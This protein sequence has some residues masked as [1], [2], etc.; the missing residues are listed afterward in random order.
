MLQKEFSLELVRTLQLKTVSACETK[1]GIAPSLSSFL[2]TL[3]G[4]R[5]RLE[6]TQKLPSS[7]SDCQLRRTNAAEQNKSPRT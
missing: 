5:L 1:L 6:E 4:Q 2:E 3:I 7:A